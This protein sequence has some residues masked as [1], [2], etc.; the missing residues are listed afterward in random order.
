ME[1]CP[2]RWYILKI[3]EIE[4]GKIHYR[5]FG[6]WAGGYLGSDAWKMNSGITEVTELN[7]CYEFLG[8]SGSTYLVH[9]ATYGTTGYGS[10]VLKGF[11]DKATL[12]EI[13]I[14][15]EETDWL[16]LKYE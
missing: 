3:T 15:P 2:D 10:M 14:M 6:T 11:M 1:Y 13:E 9:K 4:T 16:N 8:S 5:V 12:T 7:S